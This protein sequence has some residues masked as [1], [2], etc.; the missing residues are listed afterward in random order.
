MWCFVAGWLLPLVTCISTSF[1]YI[2]EQYLLYRCHKFLISSSVNRYLG[3][4]HFGVIMNI[5]VI[6]THV[7][8]MAQVYVFIIL[9]YIPRMEL[10]GCTVTVLLNFGGI[11]RLFSQENLP[12][13]MQQF[14]YV[15]TNIC[16][17]FFFKKN[18]F[19]LVG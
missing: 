15:L 4:L 12:L 18:I 6:N 11:D 7:V 9:E 13:Y 19:I 1:L 14:L 17:Q 3:G 10:L 16:K 2:N 8:I 5:I